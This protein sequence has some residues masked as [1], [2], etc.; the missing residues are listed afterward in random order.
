MTTMTKGG[1]VQ[2]LQDLLDS[3]VARLEA[4][5]YAAGIQAPSVGNVKR[6]VAGATTPPHPPL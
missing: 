5:E 3:V 1:A 6:G 4:L 2:P